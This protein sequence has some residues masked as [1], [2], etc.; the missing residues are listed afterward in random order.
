[1]MVK[2]PSVAFDVIIAYSNPAAL[3][4]LISSEWMGDRGCVLQKLAK[5]SETEHP[6]MNTKL[7]K[8]FRL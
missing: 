8:L 6:K 3:P 5:Q 1:M 7:E 4:I 2:K